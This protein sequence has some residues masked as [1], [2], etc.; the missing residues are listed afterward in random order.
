MDV[1]EAFVFPVIP[2]E[3]VDVQVKFVLETVEVKFTVRVLLEQRVVGPT[4]VAVATGIG[5]TMIEYVFCVPGQLF[6]RVEALTLIVTVCAV[7]A[8]WLSVNAG[9][10]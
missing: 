3:A 9:I 5:F 4:I 10:F 7:L 2:C 6:V 8:V 1:P